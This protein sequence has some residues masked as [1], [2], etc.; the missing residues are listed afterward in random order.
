MSS[1][2]EKLKKLKK[3]HFNAIWKR[4]ELFW[5]VTNKTLELE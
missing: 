4:D 1:T 2:T 3:K 5:L